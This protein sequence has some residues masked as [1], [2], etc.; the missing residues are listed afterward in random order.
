M[1]LAAANRSLP[2]LPSKKLTRGTELT[3]ARKGFVTVPGKKTTCVPSGSAMAPP[4]S[5]IGLVPRLAT[6]VAAEMGGS[7]KMAMIIKGI[8]TKLTTYLLRL[9]STQRTMRG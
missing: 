2:A 9:P 6:R 8:S 1:D 5:P 7:N 4:A 3:L